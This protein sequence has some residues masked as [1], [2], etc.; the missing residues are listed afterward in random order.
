MSIDLNQGRLFDFIAYQ[1]ENF[2]LDI[3]LSTKRNGE[4]RSYSTQEVL[5]LSHRLGHGLIEKGIGIGDRV[6]IISTTNRSEWNIIDLAVLQIGAVDVPIYPTITE[7]DYTYILNDSGCRIAFVSDRELFDKLTSIKAD[8]PAL[9]SIYMMDEADGIPHWTEVLHAD[10]KVSYE[11]LAP[12]KEAVRHEDLATLIYTSGTTGEPKGVML[13][14]R[15]IVTNVIGS[16]YRL[17]IEPGCKALSFLPLCHIFERMLIYLYAYKGTSI[18]YAESL[19]TIGDNLKEVAPEIFTAVPRLL[20]KVYGKIMAKGDDLTGVKRKL[21]FW[22][23]KLAE[24]FE[25]YGKNGAWYEFKLK[26][27]RKLIFSKWQEALGGNVKLAASGS[28]ALCPRVCRFYNAAGIPIMEGYGL[29]ET[30]PVVSVNEIANDGFRFGATGRPIKGVSVRIAED[31]EILVKGP[32]VMMGYYNKPDKTAEVIDQDGWFH[33]G[34]IGELVEDQYLK[35]TD[36]KKEI[37]KTS[38]GKYI[39]PQLMENAFKQNKYIEHIIIVGENKKHPSAL[40]VPA[41]ENLFDTCAEWGLDTSDKKTLLTDPKVIELYDGVMEKCNAPFARWEKVKKYTLLQEEFTIEG[42]E[43]TPTLKLKR[44]AI[45][46]KYG[47]LMK[48]LYG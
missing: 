34:D 13:S 9:E 44:K 12:L 43:L 10:T 21:F 17:P 35:I 8:C 46:S 1:N 4:W 48:D 5:D 30:S 6:A 23:V 3:S 38:G 47:D 18:Y 15:N 2:P 29:T 20:E 19:D 16:S 33:T 28:A 31:G 41:F 7:K 27:A 42:G 22:A 32:N 36:R 11:K 26:I 39:A 45:Y 14:H 37:F 40:I 25:Y 24:N